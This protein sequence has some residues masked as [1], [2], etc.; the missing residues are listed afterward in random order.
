MNAQIELIKY[1]EEERGMSSCKGMIPHY[2]YFVDSILGVMVGFTNSRKVW[3]MHIT[4]LFPPLKGSDKKWTT[5]FTGN[6]F[7]TADMEYVLYLTV[8]SMEALYEKKF[9]KVGD[10]QNKP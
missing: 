4:L 9:R 6:I 2:L 5:Q 10:I 1:L 3:P 7:S 8:D